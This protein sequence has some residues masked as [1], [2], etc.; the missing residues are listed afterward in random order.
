MG[1]R[2][3]GSAVAASSFDG[4]VGLV[5]P[6]RD[7]GVAWA[8]WLA[9][10]SAQTLVPDAFVVMDSSSDD[11]AAVAARRVGAQVVSVKS[12]D[13]DHGGT[14]QQGV[15]A[16]SDIEFVVLAT[17]DAIMTDAHAI[18][19]LVAPMETDPEVGACFGRQMPRPTAGAIEAHKR[20]FNYPSHSR[21]CSSADIEVLGVKAGFLSDTFACYRSSA[22]RAIGGF[23]RRVVLGEDLVVGARLVLAGWK[24]GYVA[25]AV[26]THS[27]AH[28][29]TDE[30]RRYFDIGVLHGSEPW[31]LAEFASAH[32]EGARYVRSEFAYLAHREPLRIPEAALRTVLKLAMYHTGRR[33][34]WLPKWARVRFSLNRTF[35]ERSV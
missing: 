9:G 31:M 3:E 6:I 24:I 11:R 1:L 5:I 18:E 34:Q 8:S 4:R 23:P 33:C 22:L 26:V 30:G 13:F 7:P 20:L 29:V 19:R 16:L 21:V 10:Y 17:Q 28:S 15:D 25:D 32:G 27:H 14:R 2:G 35:W 12:D